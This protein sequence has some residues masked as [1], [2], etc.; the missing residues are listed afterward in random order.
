MYLYNTS[1]PSP[2]MIYQFSQSP[3]RGHSGCL[4]GGVFKLSC[5]QSA[6]VPCWWPGLFGV[7]CPVSTK[8]LWWRIM[9][10]QGTSQAGLMMIHLEMFKWGSRSHFASLGGIFFSNVQVSHD[11]RPCVM[12]LPARPGAARPIDDWPQFYTK[13]Q[14]PSKCNPVTQRPGGRAGLRVFRHECQSAW[15]K[16]SGEYGRVCG[17]VA[18]AVGCCAPTVWG[19]DNTE[20]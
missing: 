6:C 15:A 17:H 5:S 2:E 12:G 4:W 13:S 8:S 16:A 1:Q 19:P 18:L 11:R 9:I 14:R 7:Y 20:N 10:L 3:V